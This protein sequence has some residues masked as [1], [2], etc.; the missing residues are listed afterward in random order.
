MEIIGQEEG[1]QT[2]IDR[3]RVKNRTDLKILNVWLLAEKHRTLSS[4]H[5]FSVFND[6]VLGTII[7]TWDRQIKIYIV[8]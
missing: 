4:I 6:Y 2:D 8:C 3:N 1:K 5:S 7:G